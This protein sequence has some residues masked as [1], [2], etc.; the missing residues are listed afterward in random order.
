LPLAKRRR[1]DSASARALLP[2]WRRPRC[3]RR[4]PTAA[5]QPSGAG[6]P[7]RAES[8]RKLPRECEGEVGPCR[9]CSDRR[10]SEDELIAHSPQPIFHR[11]ATVALAFRGNHPVVCCECLAGAVCC[12]AIPGQGLCCCVSTRATNT[13]TW[14]DMARY[15]EIWGDVGRYEHEA[16][17]ARTQL[18]GGV[19]CESPQISPDLPR[20]PQ[21]SPDLPSAGQTRSASTAREPTAASRAAS[22]RA[23]T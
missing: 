17:N 14:G 6:A 20:S 21:I 15:G 22:A 5:R 11:E 18:D 12:R 3:L 13:W 8:S 23:A 19:E 10:A 16:T 7:S 4:Q 2:A 1:R 9:V